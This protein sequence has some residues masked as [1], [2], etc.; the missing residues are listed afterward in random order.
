M[1]EEDYW[2]FCW[3]I[4]ANTVIGRRDVTGTSLFSDHLQ[5]CSGFAL[6]GRLSLCT[7]LCVALEN[8]VF[9]AH[10]VGMFFTVNRD[11]VVMV[12]EI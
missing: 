9:C 4:V 5:N 3:L 6:E 11:W 8:C 1:S 10:C 2:A 7:A 12:M